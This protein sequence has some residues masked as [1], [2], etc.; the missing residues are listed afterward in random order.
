MNAVLPHRQTLDHQPWSRRRWVT[1]IVAVFALQSLLL[2]YLSHDQNE[3][4]PDFPL[5]T[6]LYLVADPWS[7]QQLALL[8]TYRDPTLFALPN[9]NNFSGA[10]WLRFQP[11]EHHFVNW[12]EPPPW[13]ELSE[14][15]LGGAF[16][17]YIAESADAPLRIADKPLPPRGGI[18]ILVPNLPVTKE[19]TLRITGEVAGRGLR[20]LPELSSWRYSDILAPTVVR[21]V[22]EESGQVFSATLTQSSGLPEADRYALH[23]AQKAMFQPHPA[24]AAKQLNQAEPT[25]DM[26]WGSMIFQW[27]T[28]PLLE[29]TNPSGDATQP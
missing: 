9:V 18:E 2:V 26:E 24:D 28:L 3:E 7:S 23:Y 15:N 20:E 5:R 25:R 6:S 12:E 19:S 27:E 21:V 8:Q 11:M 17:Q 14:D 4:P 13:L 22:V 16:H 29:E 1:S 10:G